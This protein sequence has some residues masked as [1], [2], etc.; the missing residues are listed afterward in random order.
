MMAAPGRGPPHDRRLHPADADRVEA[1][2]RLVQ[3]EGLG[4]VQQP[5]GDGQLLLHAPGQLPRQRAPLLG[6]IQLLEQAGNPID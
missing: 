5:A 6:Q 4:L 1:G 2:E 3:E